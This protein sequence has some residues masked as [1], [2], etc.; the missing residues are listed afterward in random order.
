MKKSALVIYTIQR[1]TNHGKIESG[2]SCFRITLIN[3][4]FL[5]NESITL[6]RKTHRAI[7]SPYICFLNIML[8]HGSFMICLIVCDKKKRAD[9]AK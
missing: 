2:G 3:N 4:T 5:S 7:Y 9:K 6:R 8:H 1:K